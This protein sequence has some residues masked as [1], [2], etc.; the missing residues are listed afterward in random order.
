MATQEPFC[1]PTVQIKLGSYG[2]GYASSFALNNQCACVVRRP[3]LRPPTFRGPLRPTRR[4]C[5]VPVFNWTGGYI[6]INGGYGWGQSDWSFFG[7]DA[8]PSGGLLGLTLGY[9][10]QARQPLGVR[11]RGRHQLGR[12]QRQLRQRRLPARLPDQERLVRHRARPRRLRR[13]SRDALR[14]RRSCV[15]RRQCDRQRLRLP[16]S[17][18]NVGWTIGAGIEGAIAPNWTAKIE[19][20]YVDLGNTDCGVGPA[21]LATNVDFTATHRSR[22]HELQVLTAAIRNSKAPDESPGLFASRYQYFFSIGSP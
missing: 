2:G 6:G 3:V 8:K 18:T 4:R 13:R 9:N 5:C 19:Y 17:D 12:H 21:A 10:W 14:H 7:G 22:R 11:P 15:R 16:A 20:L 1:P